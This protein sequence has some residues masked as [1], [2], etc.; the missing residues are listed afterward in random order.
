MSESPGVKKKRA[1][2]LAGGWK[3]LPSG[4]TYFIAE[5]GNNHNGN[6]ELA[7]EMVDLA[8]EA[9]AD[10]IKFQKRDIPQ[11]AVASVLD[12]PFQISGAPEWGTTYRQVREKIELS[13]EAFAELKAYCAGRIDFLV[14]PFDLPS[15]AQM[16]EVGVDAYK[17]AAFCLTDVWLLETLAAT[18]RPVVM[19]VGACTEGE[20]REALKILEHAD[21]ALLHCVSSY[22]MRVEDANF[23]FIRWLEGFGYPVGWS[24]HEDGITLAPKAVAMGAKIVEKHFTLDRQL[25]GFDHH[26][27]LDPESLKQVIAG[28]RSVE[29]VGEADHRTGKV[30]EP[31]TRDVLPCEQQVYREKRKSLVTTV[32]IP[33]GT[34]IVREMLTAK[35]PHSGISPDQARSLAIGRRALRDIP[36]DTLLSLDLLEP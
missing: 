10:A 5:A 21:L 17:V 16:E 18:N 12:R 22:P 29:S 28:I 6:V 30:A 31:L 35:S 24:D 36:A 11:M 33:A 1:G 26:F 3:A 4:H 13:P 9:G 7:R 14:T 25:P 2:V 27:S 34:V 15:V 8:V 32:A 23:P 20:F 19:S